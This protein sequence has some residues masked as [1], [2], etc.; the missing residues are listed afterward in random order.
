MRSHFSFSLKPDPLIDNMNTNSAFK[1]N[2]VNTM[3]N[4]F[5]IINFYL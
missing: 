4:Y 2:A 1:K 5:I 3:I